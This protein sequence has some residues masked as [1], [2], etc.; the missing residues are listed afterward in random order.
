MSRAL[1]YLVVAVAIIV[2]LYVIFRKPDATPPT[3]SAPTYTESRLGPADI[4]PNPS[5]TPGISN[6][7]IVQ[8]NIDDTICNRQ[9][10][11]KFIRPPESYTHSLK[12]RQLRQYEYA[13]KDLRDY[14][15]DH[16]IPLE[17]GGHPTDPRNLWPEP[18]QGSIPEGGARYKD[19]VENYLHR[20]VCSHQMTLADAQRLIVVDWYRVYETEVLH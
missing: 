6:P 12:L 7:E 5:R 2:L 18:F 15:E 9:W 1:A 16:L 4:Y 3:T 10:S 8:G 14:E 17:L 13:D 19:K 20:Q 11:T